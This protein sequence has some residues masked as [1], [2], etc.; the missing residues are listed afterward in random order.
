M[1]ATIAHIQSALEPN[2]AAVPHGLPLPAR[3]WLALAVATAYLS[4]FFPLCRL[5]GP[6]A[7]ALAGVLVAV[8]GWLCG[9]RV[10][11]IAG[12]LFLPVN[13]LLCGLA[14]DSGRNVILPSGGTLGRV[15]VIHVVAVVVGGLVGLV[16]DLCAQL[17]E[18][19]AHLRQ[20]KL[21]LRQSEDKCRFLTENQSDLLVKLGPRRTLWFV[22]PSFCDMFGQ[23]EE[24]LLGSTFTP[25]IHEKDREKTA[26]AVKD[27]YGP[28]YSCRFAHRVMTRLGWRWLEWIGSAVLNERNGV[29]DTVWRGRDITEQE[30]IQ[31]TLRESEGRYKS[32]VENIDRGISLID[33]DY[34][35]VTT[36]GTLHSPHSGAPGDVIG[37][38]CYRRFRGLSAVCPSCPGAEAMASGQPAE[39]EMQVVQDDGESRSLRVQAFPTFG[40]DGATTGFIELVDDLT[41][42]KS[43]EEQLRQAQRMEAI[44]HLAGGIAHD[45]SNLLTVINGYSEDI[46]KALDSQAPLRRKLEPI[47]QAGLRAASLTRSLLAFA[48][49]Q[50]VRK[51]VLDL[52]DVL[53]GI[54][55]MLRRLIDE[56][57]QLEINLSEDLG[58]VR[59]GPGQIEQVVFNL[60]VNAR[61]AMPNGGTLTLETSNVWLD[62]TNT[63]GYLR[64][65]PGPYIL[66]AVSDTGCGMSAD[67]KEHLFEPFFTTKEPG[68]GTGLGLATVYRIIEESGGNIQVSSA[69]GLG[70]TFKI[71]L[72][73]VN[74]TPER[75]DASARAAASPRG[76]E[77]ILVV[78]DQA[79]VCEFSAYTLRRL[80]YTVLVAPDG[81]K[82]LALVRNRKQP[83]DLVLADLV[84]PHMCGREFVRE[85]SKLQSGFGVVYMSGY[86]D[87]PAYS[88]HFVAKPFTMET[89]ARTVREA[90]DAR[91][92]ESVTDGPQLAIP[93]V[94]ETE[95][96]LR[97]GPSHADYAPAP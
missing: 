3:A 87:D 60:A 54:G 66:L 75:T 71:Y 40:P 89:L 68:K 72:P 10:G 44:G 64:V 58:S 61:D 8:V 48:S 1:R 32:L 95:Q 74:E 29:M 12:L 79:Y 88:A 65:K 91:G 53:E 97:T 52:N 39:G 93:F 57:I 21:A 28:P 6:T 47:H 41:E 25:L 17:G 94:V 36:N 18:A 82:A 55:E 70:T 96:R 34:R 42:R 5:V 46:L 86:S 69:P 92:D 59:I 33:T 51:R 73:Q 81:A 80:G 13:M 50:A 76:S 15:V 45:F 62:E 37:R 11:L 49:R 26:Q 35:I 38:K 23:T 56:R 14:E 24:E 90:L 30:R 67:V 16:H 27:V 84:M 85:L 9:L 19:F 77:T 78:E 22:S 2:R 63:S 31:N 7:C 43:L 83:I 20:S 4:G